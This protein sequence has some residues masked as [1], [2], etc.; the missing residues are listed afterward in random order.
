MTELEKT[1]AFEAFMRG[2]VAGA[3]RSAL[4][5]GYRA[6]EYLEGHA[7]G[8][9]VRKVFAEAVA[10]RLDLDLPKDERC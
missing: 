1:F 8:R 4:E 5:S 9:R 2:W 7:V 6:P 10:A 3:W